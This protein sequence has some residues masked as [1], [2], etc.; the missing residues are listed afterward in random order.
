VDE[1]GWYDARHLCAILPD[2]HIDGARTFAEG[3][4]Q[5]VELRGGSTPSWRVYSYPEDNVEQ[6]RNDETA[7]RRIEHPAP[8]TPSGSISQLMVQPLPR[9]KRMTDIV[10][11][12]L[13]LA[14]LSPLLFVT[15]ALIRLTSPGPI[16]FRQKRRGLGGRVFTIYKFRSMVVGADAKKAALRAQ[17]EQDG[18]AFK[19][20]HD[21]RVTPIGRWIRKTSVDELPQLWNVLKGD[22]SLVGPRP[23]PVAES[24]E[25]LQWQL[26]RLSVTPGLTC[27]WQVAGRS[28]VSFAQWVGMDLR[29]IRRRTI[30]HDFL[31]LL[32]TIPAVLLRRG[33][34]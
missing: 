18:P 11:A 34:R 26:H 7:V 30:G 22:M 1:V 27:I 5:R 14:L 19:M 13:L 21:P 23:L 31:I 15:A 29:Y 12:G 6:P 4:R 8:R 20:K 25:C 2:T 9:W 32:R 16:I 24:D 33:A 17:S 10:G 3:V 28:Q